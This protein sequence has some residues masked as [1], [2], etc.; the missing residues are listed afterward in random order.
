MWPEK[1]LTT[2]PKESRGETSPTRCSFMNLL[3]AGR[4]ELGNLIQYIRN[5]AIENA[6]TWPCLAISWDQNDAE[7]QV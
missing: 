6:D 4:S 7:K 5:N 3:S 1:E 2:V